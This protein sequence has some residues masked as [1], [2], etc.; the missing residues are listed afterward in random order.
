MWSRKAR[1]PRIFNEFF[2]KRG[3]GLWIYEISKF[4]Q[5]IQYFILSEL[6]GFLAI[7]R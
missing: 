2:Q 5:F 3:K 1:N 6:E 4:I 7:Q